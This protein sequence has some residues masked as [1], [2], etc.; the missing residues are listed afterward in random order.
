MSGMIGRARAARR[1]AK[2]CQKRESVYYSTKRAEGTA[3]AAPL[4]VRPDKSSYD[5]G[6]GGRAQVARA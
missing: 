6:R 5:P 2:S 4:G 1:G 3:I